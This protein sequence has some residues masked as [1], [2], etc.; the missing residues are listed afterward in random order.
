M[1]DGLPFR[2]L[3][4]EDDEDDRMLIDEAFLQIDYGSEVK[5]FRDGKSML[6]YLDKVKPDLYPTLIVLDNNLPGWDAADMLQILKDTS[7]YQQIRV[8]V[9]STILSA[10]LKEKLLRAGAHACMEKGS[11]FEELIQLAT[12]LKKLSQQSIKEA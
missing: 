3:V 8:I 10:A 6:D 5:K 2:I 9:Y 12:E 11:T 1:E 7:A 4:V